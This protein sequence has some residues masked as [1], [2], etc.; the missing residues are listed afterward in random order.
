MNKELFVKHAILYQLISLEIKNIIESLS[1]LFLA[2][3]QSPALI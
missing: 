3:P 1:I 2:G